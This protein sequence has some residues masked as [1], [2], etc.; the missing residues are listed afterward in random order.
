MIGDRYEKSI[1]QIP[2]LDRG[3]PQ[4]HRDQT[5]PIAHAN[6]YTAKTVT[7]PTLAQTNK[8]RTYRLIAT[9]KYGQKEGKRWE[10]AQLLLYM[11]RPSL[12]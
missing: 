9:D 12:V 8:G 7:F 11:Q 2:R 6:K 1:V 10:K 5:S 3:S 4:T